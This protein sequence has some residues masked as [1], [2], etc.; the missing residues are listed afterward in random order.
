MSFVVV[1]PEVMASAATDLGGIGSAIAAANS[2]A[3]GVITELLPAAADDVSAAVAAV[4]GAHGQAYQGISQQLAA[5]HQQL[6]HNLSAGAASYA[7]AEAASV[8]PLQAVEQ[9]VLAAINAPS[10]VLL[11]RPLIGDGASGTAANP[12]GGAGGTGGVNRQ[13]FSIGGTGGTGG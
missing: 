8:N 1:G 6:V 13:L 10:Q 5:F 12:N 4:F 3:S 9:N 11:G 7:A 2:A